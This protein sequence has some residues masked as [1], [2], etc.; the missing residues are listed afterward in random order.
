ML[1]EPKTPSTIQIEVL[2][3]QRLSQ[4]I[5]STSSAQQIDLL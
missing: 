2:S 3:I 5:Q 4:N 1:E